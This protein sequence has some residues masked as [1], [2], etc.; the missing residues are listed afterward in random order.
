MASDGPVSASDA[1][2]GLFGATGPAG[3][4]GAVRGSYI[5]GIDTST[6][7]L[8]VAARSADGCE[9]ATRSFERHLDGAARLASIGRDT[10]GFVRELAGEWRP[11]V[12][13]VEEIAVFSRRVNPILYQA[14]GAIQ[15]ALFE[16]L[17]DVGVSPDVRMIA[18]SSWK[19][20]ALGQGN[21]HAP[22]DRIFKWAQADGYG[23][24]L[25]DEA[26]AWG[27]ARAGWSIASPGQQALVV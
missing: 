9:V 3:G 10:R 13:F 2:G 16:G 21:G 23:G 19:A 1:L 5:W 7:R 8:S 24:R 11:A 20:R 18:V 17:V 26:D 25:E 6:Q 4:S 14:H 12:V 27:I 15:A 22:K